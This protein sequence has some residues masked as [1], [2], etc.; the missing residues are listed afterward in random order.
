MS[1][2]ETSQ[3]RMRS[4]QNT[5]EVGDGGAGEEGQLQSAVPR[6]QQAMP[7]GTWMNCSNFCMW[8]FSWASLMPS[9]SQRRFRVSIL[10]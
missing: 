8:A 6:L 10:R 1:T 4:Q 5:A 3:P 9:S 7:L 2:Q